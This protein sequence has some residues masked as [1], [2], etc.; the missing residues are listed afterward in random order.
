MPPFLP[1]VARVHGVGD[2]QAQENS[3]LPGLWHVLMKSTGVGMGGGG[4]RLRKP[5]AL[6]CYKRA[7][8]M[9][10][11]IALDN[12]CEVMQH[13]CG[14]FESTCA[15]VLLPGAAPGQTVCVG[16]WVNLSRQPYTSCVVV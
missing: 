13:T 7:V 11:C 14:R 5:I 4:G 6:G 15:R 10:L 16:L 9:G 2:G 8:T 1:V 3:R 12:P